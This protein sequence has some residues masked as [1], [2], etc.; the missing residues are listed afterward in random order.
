MREMKEQSSTFMENT[1]VLKPTDLLWSV[2]KRWRGIIVVML[3]AGI[4][5]GGYG[6]YKSYKAYK[7]PKT[8]EK[9]QQEYEE[10]LEQYNQSVE[11]YETRL[12][13][14]E[15]WVDKLNGYSET[16]LLLLMD[17]YNVYK[18]T[19]TYYIDTGYEI[20]PEVYYQNP[21]Y[22]EALVKGY[23][24]AI[25]RLDFETLIDLPG[26][27]DLTTEHPILD[28]VS[29]TVY[30][31]SV[32]TGAGL[33]TIRLI[34]DSEKR[35]D[36]IL[37]AIDSIIKEQKQ[38]MT[39]AIGEHEVTLLSEG[40]ETTIDTDLVTL[41]NT[42]S[43]EYESALNSISK[44]QAK[45]DELQKPVKPSYNRM[46]VIK[47]GIKYGIIGLAA[48][49]FGMIIICLLPLC[50]WNRLINVEDVRDRYRQTVLG[51]VQISAKKKN[52]LDRWIAKKLGILSDQSQEEA[53]DYIYENVKA[54]LGEE[55]NVLVIG[56]IKKDQLA[57]LCDLLNAKGEEITFIPGGDVNTSPDALRALS[58]KPAVIVTEEWQ[59][60]EHLSILHELDR[61]SNAGIEKTGFVVLY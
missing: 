19:R 23:R 61:I 57:K 38:I 56:S 2:L 28:Q 24:N 3:I 44:A 31:T 37:S 27:A 46:S 40:A 39:K 12:T 48:G 42:F 41:Q 22:T 53:I 15:T 58:E 26:E 30:S 59:T 50:G 47:D 6:F 32:D 7:N 34:C 29:K 1:V 33:L 21:N 11:L 45:L 49:L 14:L 52:K 4:I 60:S 5:I 55:A 54:V 9:N 8:R 16:S 17:P 13:N 18:V 10:A 43:S 51:T 36:Q 35:A 25:D 20:M